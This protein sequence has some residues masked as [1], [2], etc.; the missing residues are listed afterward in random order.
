MLSLF[1]RKPD[2]FPTWHDA[3]AYAGLSYCP[4][5]VEISQA[6][7]GLEIPTGG[8]WAFG[9]GTVWEQDFD[10]NTV[11]ILCGRLP[12]PHSQGTTSLA[13]CQ[14]TWIATARINVH[15]HTRT[16]RDVEAIVAKSAGDA[17]VRECR[18]SAALLVPFRV[19]VDPRSFGQQTSSH[20]LPGD[21]RFSPMNSVVIE[22]SGA[23]F[24]AGGGNWSWKGGRDLLTVPRSALPLLSPESARAMIEECDAA[25]RAKA[26]A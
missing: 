21:A 22:C 11:A 26:A 24:I 8:G 25:M 14:R 10:K 13:D 19:D 16:A 7:K 1:K 3:P 23:C 17:P 12:W 18:D 2:P 5:P 15:S 6:E 9:G 20:R 4:L